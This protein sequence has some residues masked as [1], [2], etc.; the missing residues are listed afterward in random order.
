MKG[1]GVLRM[2]CYSSY[3]SVVQDPAQE[4]LRFFVKMHEFFAFLL[5]WV[6]TLLSGGF[7]VE[8]YH[9]CPAGAQH[10]MQLGW[11]LGTAHRHCWA[12]CLPAGIAVGQAL[13]IHL[14]TSFP[15]PFWCSFPARQAENK[16]WHHRALC[17]SSPWCHTANTCKHMETGQPGMSQPELWPT[18]QAETAHVPRCHPCKKPGSGSSW[19]SSWP[20]CSTGCLWHSLL[21]HVR[22]KNGAAAST[23]AIPGTGYGSGWTSFPRVQRNRLLWPRAWLLKGPGALAFAIPRTGPGRGWTWLLSD[24]SNHPLS[25]PSFVPVLEPPCP[26]I[27]PGCSYNVWGCSAWLVLPFASAEMWR[28]LRDREGDGCPHFQ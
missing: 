19:W 12:Q 17:D 3:R 10:W 18:W 27:W 1:N 8:T 26:L 25:A 7:S 6:T 4:G 24:W 28:N 23:L 9:S 20:W 16:L 11:S 13:K 2:S 5:A 21:P 14:P 15:A 22:L